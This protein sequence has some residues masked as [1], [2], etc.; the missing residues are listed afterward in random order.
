MIR[1]K[2]NWYGFL[3]T[4]FFVPGFLICQM[5]DCV[6]L[7]PNKSPSFSL[8]GPNAA[9][10]GEAQKYPVGTRETMDQ[11]EYLF[12]S[13]NHFDTI[14]TAK[15]VPSSRYYMDVPQVAAPTEY[16]LLLSCRTILAGSSSEAK[17]D[18]RAI[19]RPK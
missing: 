17:S 1:F 6:V 14:F 12:G 19:D 4:L 5:T 7:A 13:Y 8:A 16:L 9:E 10:N 15:A 11:P 3:L 2:I 18:N